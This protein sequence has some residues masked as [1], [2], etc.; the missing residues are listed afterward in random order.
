MKMFQK[1]VIQSWYPDD[2]DSQRTPR[3]FVE[4][5]KPGLLVRWIVT[6]EDIGNH[7]Q[8]PSSWP[9]SSVLPLISFLRIWPASNPSSVINMRFSCS[10]WDQPSEPGIGYVSWCRCPT[11]SRLVSLL[12]F[13]VRRDVSW[14]VVGSVVMVA[15]PL[16]HSCSLIFVRLSKW[17]VAAWDRARLSMMTAPRPARHLMLAARSLQARVLNPKNW[18]KHSSRR[19]PPP[20]SASSFLLSSSEHVFWDH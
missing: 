10:I 8:A 6:P 7:L 12:K 1:K 2:Y 18:R 4:F 17:A 11:P 16:G 3:P 19:R 20:P 9:C 14:K 5:P 13:L 15:L